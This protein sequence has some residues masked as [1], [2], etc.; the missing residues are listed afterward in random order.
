MGEEKVSALNTLYQDEVEKI[1]NAFLSKYKTTDEQCSHALMKYK[2]DEKIM[3]ICLQIERLNRSFVSEPLTQTELDQIPE[4][5]TVDRLID[6]MKEMNLKMM[7]LQQQVYSE[8]QAFQSIMSADELQ[9][10][11]KTMF[12]TRTQEFQQN[13]LAKHE[14]NED[15]VALAMNKYRENPKLQNFLMGLQQRPT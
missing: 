14:V 8:T 1:R 3:K 15:I 5:F 9:K 11:Q 6:M 7:E 13:I 12:E 4:S 10:Q 2:E